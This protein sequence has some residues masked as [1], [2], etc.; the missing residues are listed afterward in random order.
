M[1]RG[2]AVSACSLQWACCSRPRARQT[3][4]TSPVPRKQTCQQPRGTGCGCGC[5]C[6]GAKPSSFPRRQAGASRAPG[7][8][9]TVCLSVCVR[10]LF[11]CW[12]VYVL[13]F[14]PFEDPVL[15]LPVKVNSGIARSSEA[16]C[17]H[18]V[19]ESDLRP[20]CSRLSQKQHL[21]G[22][23]GT[24]TVMCCFFRGS[25]MTL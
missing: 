1:P 16:P 18:A 25:L 10:L 14:V 7:G 4:S 21:R 17:W 12:R 5:R 11:L 3:P 13:L 23:P 22:H 6:R 15:R 9:S 19:P 20:L 8:A 2:A 24:A